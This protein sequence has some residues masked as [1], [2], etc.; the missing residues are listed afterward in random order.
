[1]QLQ[2]GEKDKDGIMDDFIKGVNCSNIRTRRTI[3]IRIYLDRGFIRS[4]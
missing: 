4:Y 2:A 1:M 3:Y